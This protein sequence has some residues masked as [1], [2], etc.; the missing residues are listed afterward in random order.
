MLGSRRK[1][2]QPWQLGWVPVP[3]Q[4]LEYPHAHILTVCLCF[5]RCAL[6]I[7][8]F[9]LDFRML[10]VW[11]FEKGR[12]KPQMPVCSGPFG[13]SVGPTDIEYVPKGP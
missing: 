5:F 6:H 11:G 1:I 9:L 7:E 8:A 12:K 3:T 2:G 13:V 10:H 4:Q